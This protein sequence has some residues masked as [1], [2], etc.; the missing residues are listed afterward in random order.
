MPQRTRSGCCPQSWSMSLR[1]LQHIHC[2]PMWHQQSHLPNVSA[3]LTVTNWLQ[4]TAEGGIEY[5]SVV[6]KVGINVAAWAVE[7]CEW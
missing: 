3:K 4:L 2:W 7:D 6:G 1:S 5:D